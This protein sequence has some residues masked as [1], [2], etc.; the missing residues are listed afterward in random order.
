MVS[1]LMLIGLHQKVG[2]Q[3][4]LLLLMIS[5]FVLYLHITK[6]L[7]IYIDQCSTWLA[8]VESILSKVRYKV[9][10]IKCQHVQWTLLYLFGLLTRCL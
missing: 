2:G 3:K 5:H 1:G 8:H 6:Y 10:Y 9:N 7:G 4:W